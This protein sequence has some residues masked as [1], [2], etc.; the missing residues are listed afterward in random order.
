[1]RR[2][3]AFGAFWLIAV[4]LLWAPITREKP[5]ESGTEWWRVTRYGLYGYYTVKEYGGGN[6]S[7]LLRP[8][9]QHYPPP[10]ERAGDPDAFDLT[11]V[12]TLLVTL[13][14]G[15]CY[16]ETRTPPPGPS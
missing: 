11:L 2:A 10:P 7:Q 13:L 1:M 15:A 6:G 16:R 14:T 12:A 4:G 8:D 9:G 3:A 5:N